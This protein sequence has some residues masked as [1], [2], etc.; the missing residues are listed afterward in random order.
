[1]KGKITR[2]AISETDDLHQNQSIFQEEKKIDP[3]NLAIAYRGEVLA[4]I[5][6]GKEKKKKM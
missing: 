1:V 2:S 5:T 6:T 4:G 3:G